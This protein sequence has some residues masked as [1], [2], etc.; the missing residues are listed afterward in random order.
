MPIQVVYLQCYLVV[1]W[2]VPREAAG[3]SA[4]VLCIP[5]N[6]APVYNACSCKSKYYLGACMSSCNL[7][8]ARLAERPGSFTCRCGNAGW[9]GCQ[10]KSQHRKLT[11]EKNFFPAASAGTRTRDLSITGLALY[12]LSY[13]LSPISLKS[14]RIP[15]SKAVRWIC[16]SDRKGL[17]TL[18]CYGRPEFRAQA[19]HCKL[20]L[21]GLR[22]WW[23]WVDA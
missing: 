2:L 15:P 18:P 19:E 5:Y 3:V 13:P 20:S 9:N 16:R 6:H 17:R 8:A 14:S 10:N 21:H 22:W 1:V 12:P 7:P 23:W 4:H 11:L